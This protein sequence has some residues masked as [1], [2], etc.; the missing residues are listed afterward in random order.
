MEQMAP[1]Q[2]QELTFH[3][4]E[5]FYQAM[6][7]K[8]LKDRKRISQL[9]PYQAK[10]A[11]R[12]LRLRED[13]ESIK[14]KVMLYALRH[15]FTKTP[16]WKNK[17]LQTPGDIIENNNWHDLFWGKCVCSRHRGKGKNKLGILL[18]QIRAELLG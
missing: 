13:W 2:Y 7:T 4:V 18:M 15:K 11:G 14:E 10:K 6:K 3:T 1:L 5:N 8:D 12:K 16:K 17:L 9:N